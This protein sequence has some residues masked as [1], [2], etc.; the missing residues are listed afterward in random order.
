MDAPEG[1]ILDTQSARIIWQDI[2]G[3]IPLLGKGQ[4]PT[5]TPSHGPKPVTVRLSVDR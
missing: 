2:G 4:Q 1:G 5:E 3:E